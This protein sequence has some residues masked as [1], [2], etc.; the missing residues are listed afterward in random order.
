MEA[1]HQLLL[2]RNARETL[3]FVAIH[4]SNARRLNQIDALQARCEELEHDLI[5]QREVLDQHA[6]DPQEGRSGIMTHSIAMKNETRLREK[7]EKLQEELNQKLKIHA[8]DQASAIQVVKD[9][10]ASKDTTKELEKT[11]K[12]IQEES[13][14]KDRAMQHL[15]NELEDAKSRT[16]L[17]EQQYVGLK[18]TIRILQEENDVIKKENRTLE[19]RLVSDKETLIGEMNQLSEMCERLKKEVEMLRSLKAE[20]DKRK[21]TSSSFFG[22]STSESTLA[23]K[24]TEETNS[25]KFNPMIT[26]VVPSKARQAIRAHAA[27]A[28]CLRYEMPQATEGRCIQICPVPSHFI[29]LFCNIDT[30]DRIL[31]W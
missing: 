19:T 14:K 4:E 9:L 2:E 11:I 16:K 25:R 30:T 23:A 3:P 13:D 26:V 29:F 31:T 18:D 12:K 17:A 24:S 10:A 22:I 7:L 8:E 15:K 27:E 5:A 21:T 28:S 20:E 1:L 6:S